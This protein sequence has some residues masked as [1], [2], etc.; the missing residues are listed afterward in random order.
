MGCDTLNL[1]HDAH[2]ETLIYKDVFWVPVNIL[3]N[4]RYSNEELKELSELVSEEKRVVVN[5]L[6]EAIQFYQAGGFV[7][8][9]DNQF[10]RDK[11]I[12]WEF[13]KP[14]FY[15]VQTNNICCTSSAN[16]L[17]YIIEGKY[18]DHGFITIYKNTMNTHVLNYIKHE[19]F[20]Y[21]IDMYGHAEKFVDMISPETGV[22]NDFRKSKIITGI[23]FKTKSFESFTNF[24]AKFMYLSMP[25]HLFFQHK[26][27]FIYSCALVEGEDINTVFWSDNLDIKLIPHKQKVSSVTYK[28]VSPPEISLPGMNKFNIIQIG[29]E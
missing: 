24:Y 29:D 12:E 19:G 23:C 27:N 18:E 16:W 11:G 21:I 22:I 8:T 9:E 26:T 25:E 28:F 15:A 2:F 20:I 6:Y 14:G 10:V 17:S 1:R 5:T 4:S 13:H 7:I 3:G